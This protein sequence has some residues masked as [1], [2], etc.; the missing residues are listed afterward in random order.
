MADRWAER[1][2]GDFAKRK[3][4]INATGEDLP[5]LSVTKDRGVVLQSDKYNK[6]V[7]TDP[8]KYVIVDDGDFAFD[9]MSLYYGALGR[10]HGIGRGLISPDYVAFTIDPTVDPTFVEYKLRSQHMVRAYERVAQAGNM[11]GKRRRVYWS[12]LADLPVRLPPVPEQREIASALKAMDD[13]IAAGDAVIE[14][15]ER[16][17]RAVANELLRRGMPA[18]RHTMHRTE[19]GDIPASWHAVRLGDVCGFSGGNGFTPRDWSP[20]GLPIIRIQNLNGSRDFNYFAGE[21]R[22]E[23]LVQPGLLLFAWAGSR[24]SSFGPCLWPGPVGVLNQH[25]HKLAPSDDVNRI[26]LFYVLELFTAEVERRAHGFKSSLVHLRKAELTNLTFGLPPLDEQL[27]IVATL[28]SVAERI[29]RERAVLAQRR[30]LKTALADALLTGKVHV[31][32]AGEEAEVTAG[33]V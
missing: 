28:E 18:H 11:Y 8:R 33:R 24:G 9:P 21:P 20:R 25:I 19:I 15:L 7:A 29:E 13:A 31:S 4:V 32:L 2:V 1:R 26:F 6:R 16:V 10:V 22:P 30:L 27:E 17:R 14:Q 5:P 12:V 23:W 3:K